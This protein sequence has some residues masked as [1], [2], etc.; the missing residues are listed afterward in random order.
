MM[1]FW[2]DLDASVSL[3]TSTTNVALPNV[4]VAGIPSGATIIRVIGMLHP[5]HTVDTSGGINGL[6]AAAVVNVKKSTGAWG[7]DDVALINFPANSWY[8][9]ASSRSDG[10]MFVGDN[11]AASEV[12]GNATYNL[13]FNGNAYAKGF[14]LG[15]VDVAVGLRVYFT[16]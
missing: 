12:D 10:R 6:A 8:T 2:S 3:S 7:T 5:R 4:I 11:D 14:I 9:A 16:P 15:L 1:E 13:R